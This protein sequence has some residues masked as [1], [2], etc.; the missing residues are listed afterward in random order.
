[1]ATGMGR[2]SRIEGVQGECG[3]GTE[4]KRGHKNARRG[5]EGVVVEDK[6]KGFG[7]GA[8]EV[9]SDGLDHFEGPLFLRVN[10]HW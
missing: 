10:D 1:M 2:E 5:W 9:N 4:R 6:G 3:S 8:D 7:D